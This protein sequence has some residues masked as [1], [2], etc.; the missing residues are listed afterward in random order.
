[1]YLRRLVESIAYLMLRIEDLGR[2]SKSQLSKCILH[3][4]ILPTYFLQFED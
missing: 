2:T 4:S 1:M 3:S